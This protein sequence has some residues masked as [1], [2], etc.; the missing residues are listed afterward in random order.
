M[1]SLKK[2]YN[3][4]IKHSLLNKFN[5][6]DV[7]KLPKI[8]EITLSLDCK[9]YDFKRIASSLLAL[10]LITTKR[11]RINSAKK[12]NTMLKIRKG[13][14]VGCKVRLTKNLSYV[15]II[16]LFS[17]ILP[18]IKNTKDFGIKCDLKNYK[19]TS[20]TF[21]N[22]LI[23]FEFE[24]NYSLFNK[25]PCLQVTILTNS[26]TKEELVFLLRSLKINTY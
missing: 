5:Y 8:N 26:K 18:K 17:E 22:N 13:N 21:K 19:S 12:S 10:E 1:V 3:N 6:K 11:G 9:Q 24:D 25:L 16:K 2:F 20:Y 23:F 7:V 14:P 15:F 4:T